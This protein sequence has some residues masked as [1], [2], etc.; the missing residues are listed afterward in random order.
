MWSDHESIADYI[1]YHYLV[2]TITRIINNDELLPCSIG[3]YGDWGSGKSSLMRMV[4]QVYDGQKDVLVIK[5][6][7]WLFEGY[8]D[9]KTV[10][11]GRIVDEIIEK[12]TLSEKAFKLANKLLHRINW[13]KVAGATAKYGAAFLTAGPVGVAAVGAH[14]A[15]VKLKEVDYEKYIADKNDKEKDPDDTLRHNIQEFHRNF[16]E[17]IAETNLKKIIV[18]IDDLDR[19]SPDTIIG[20]LEAIKLFLFTKD[21]AFVI[22]ADE[23]LIKYAVRRRFPE[24]P[25]ENLEVG[26]DYL[27]KLIQYPVRIP[28]LSA[29]E[30]TTY[31]NLLFSKLYCNGDFEVIR[32][33]VITKKRSNG[34]EFVYDLSNYK[35]FFADTS[36]ELDDAIALCAQIVP[37]LAVGLNGNPRQVKRFLNTLL[38]RLQMAETK[39]AKLK[40]RVMA[41]LMLLE[42]FKPETFT[43]FHDQQ[44]AN[45]GKLP[46]LSILENPGE[47]ALTPEQKLLTEDNWIADWLASDPKLATENLQPYFY[48]S[49]DKLGV[50]ASNLQRMSPKSQDVIQKLLS[51]SQALKTNAIK[52]F[53]KLSSSDA[54][55]IFEAL[56]DKIRQGES[57]NDNTANLKSIFDLVREKSELKSQLMTFLQKQPEASLPLSIVPLTESLLKDSDAKILKEL[58]TKWAGSGNSKLVAVAKKSLK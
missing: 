9:A 2:T 5:F 11:L 53:S 46:V 28:P 49:R 23:R 41:K 34:Y 27:E 22:G 14:E 40:K 17:L 13:I 20:T 35:N 57:G 26:R 33:A 16:E 37:V 21:T 54:A 3:I 31:I 32:G 39:G 8:E 24:V 29:G 45:G 4:E 7:G 51:N 38:I 56:A 12:R 50:T 19:C 44:A 58:L 6:N 10:L 30:L 43:S 48:V 42:Y 47:D 1:D 52:E 25:G 55:S 15:I 18:F 36:P